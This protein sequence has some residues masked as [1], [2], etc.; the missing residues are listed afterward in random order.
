MQFV[1]NGPDVP[2]ELIQ[3]H[4]DGNLVFFCGSGISVPAGLPNFK[5]LV[6]DVVKRAG[7]KPNELASN[8]I[9][10]EIYDNAFQLLETQYVKERNGIRAEVWRILNKRIK[11]IDRLK[12][13]ISLLNL[14]QVDGKCRLVTTNYDRLFHYAAKKTSLYLNEYCAPFIPIPKRSRWDGV[15]FLHGLLPVKEDPIMLNNLVLTSGDFG[16]AYLTERWA[17]K[18]IAELFRDFDVCFIGYSLQDTVLKYMTDAI[19]SDRRVGDNARKVWAFTDFD[20]SSYDYKIVEWESKGVHPVLYKKLKGVKAHFL[21]HETIQEWSKQY[22]EG[23][24][25][26][27]MIVRM[28]GLR[29][30][31]V[32]TK[33]DDFVGRIKWVLTDTSGIPAKTFANLNPVPDLEWLFKVFSVNQFG[34]SDLAK[35]EVKHVPNAVIEDFSFLNR[36]ARY[37]KAKRMSLFVSEGSDTM[38]D[39]IMNSMAEWLTRHLN[40]RRLFLWVITSGYKANRNFKAKLERTLA[41]IH[42]PDGRN[43]AELELKNAPQSKPDA[44]MQILWR[45]YLNDKILTTE[46]SLFT[47]IKSKLSIYGFTPI[48]RMELREIIALKISVTKSAF[49]FLKEERDS[50]NMHLETKLALSYMHL[51]LDFRDVDFKLFGD[52]LHEF[53]LDIQNALYDGLLLLAYCDSNSC[54][55]EF[56]DSIMD[57]PSIEDHFQNRRYESWVFLVELLRD[58]WLYLMNKNEKKAIDIALNWFEVP[59]P[60]FKRLAFFAAYKTEAVPSSIWVEWLLKNDSKWLWSSNVSREVYRLLALKGNKPNRLEL[61]RLETTI[62]QGPDNSYSRSTSSPVRKAYDIWHYLA[63][64]HISG[65][66]LSKNALSVLENYQRENPSW[67]IYENQKDEFSTWMEIGGFQRLDQ[68]FIGFESMEIAQMIQYISE[69]AE[70]TKSDRRFS[71]DGWRLFCQNE[72]LK[73]IEVLDGVLKLGSLES[74]FWREALEAWDTVELSNEEWESIV[75]H[76]R[77]LSIEQLIGIYHQVGWWLQKST[78][79]ALRKRDI[80]L[81]LVHD[82]LNLDVPQHS[83]IRMNGKSFQELNKPIEEAINH[84]IGHL[85]Q[86]VLNTW[87]LTNP[88]VSSGIEEDFK[89]L[90]TRFCS[91]ENPKYIH[92]KVIL[93]T[94]LNTLFRVDIFWTEKNLLPLFD[95]D[96]GALASAVWQG[97]MWSPS[98]YPDLLNRLKPGLIETAKNWKQLGDLRSKYVSYVTQIGLENDHFFGIL[99]L[100]ELFKDLNEVALSAFLETHLEFL[101]YVGDKRQVYLESRVMPHIKRVFPK[102]KKYKHSRISALFARIAIKSDSYFPILFKEIESWLEPIDNPYLLLSE[103]KESKLCETFPDETL[104]LIALIVKPVPFFRSEDL[105]TC[106]IKVGLS[107]QTLKLTDLYRRLELQCSKLIAN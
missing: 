24:A 21:L 52:Q 30:P 26:K 17:S 2:D 48:F 74:E 97:Y 94:H 20:D 11:S 43:D 69:I 7:I 4:L 10:K 5:D 12:T 51:K 78:K 64:L 60:V 87:Y 71:D 59:F 44:M 73:S 99:T 6:C 67:V 37:D 107:N 102:D 34:T 80:L 45:L 68:N 57:L 63:K 42:E 91:E 22:T 27:Q 14:S 41:T 40:D 9:S 55:D 18:F 13:H 89:E 82:L 83:N 66:K 35:F 86:S 47:N 84:F 92:A 103:L 23:I 79:S 101:D 33:A 39:D 105:C 36:P 50:P 106:L 16:T 70:D 8:A 88:T 54:N 25:S 76:L 38:W 29:L 62:L 81:F 53:V 104:K 46:N 1:V 3:S 90:F 56:D 72:V 61:K 19:S 85:T 75:L 65:A 93:A 49:N 77:R 100:E 15:V 96:R 28:D 31:S 32:N 95:W 58:S 98:L